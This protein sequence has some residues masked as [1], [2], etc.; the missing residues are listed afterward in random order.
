MKVLSE[1]I[2]KCMSKEDRE[3]YAKGQLTSDEALDKWARDQERKV[4]NLF[5]NWLLLHDLDYDHSRMDKKTTSKKGRPDF[6]VW[7]GLYHCFVEFKSEH[8]RLRPEQKEFLKRQIAKGTPV[9]VTTSFVEAI[10]FVIDA[11]ALE[12]IQVSLPVDGNSHTPCETTSGL[13]ESENQSPPRSDRIPH[14][15]DNAEARNLEH[16]ELP[17]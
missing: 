7:K 9:L 6:H 17:L 11:F 4:H 12:W 10:R 13:A 14:T 3:K 8:G 1:N 2:L 5:V 15:P 16:P